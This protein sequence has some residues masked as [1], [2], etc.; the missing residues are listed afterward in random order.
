LQLT[1][2]INIVSNNCH[3]AVNPV[4]M[5]RKIMDAKAYFHFLQVNI[6]KLLEI[7]KKETE[8]GGN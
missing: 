4:Y 6:A 8:S 1:E 7:R 5:D 3:E 2:A